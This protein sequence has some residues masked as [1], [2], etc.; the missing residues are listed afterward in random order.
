MSYLR[1]GDMRLL[2]RISFCHK[3]LLQHAAGSHQTAFTL[4]NFTTAES[5][6][7]HTLSRH[8][9]LHSRACTKPKT[10]QGTLA[11]HNTFEQSEA[12]WQIG[13]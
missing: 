5:L 3:F 4:C 13:K 1:G 12:A 6:P 2:A 7:E 11:V 10:Y 9:Q 8:R